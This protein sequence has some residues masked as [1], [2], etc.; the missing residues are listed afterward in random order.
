MKVDTSTHASRA[1]FYNSLE[2]VHMREAILIRD[3]YECQWCKAAGRVTNI[4]NAILEVDHIK[5][6]EQFP[7]LA[8]DPNNLRTL[9]KDCHN[10]RHHRF[11]WA[12]R[13]RPAK[14]NKWA[15]DERWD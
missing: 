2:W 13:N 5:P 6:L 3:N 4:N 10:K 12:P 1:A 7:E 9:C 15:T 8:L 14:K 11:N